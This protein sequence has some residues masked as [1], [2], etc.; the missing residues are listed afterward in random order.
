MGSVVWITLTTYSELHFESAGV[1]RL[2]LD[3]M[4]SG[5]IGGSA[6]SMWGSSDGIAELT[7]R[8]SA[9]LGVW[10][11]SLWSVSPDAIAIELLFDVDEVKVLLSD[12]DELGYLG[13]RSG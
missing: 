10:R 11:R 7:S 1:K 3:L 13:K 6:K 9:V 4:T 5:Y 8:H 2:I 12:L